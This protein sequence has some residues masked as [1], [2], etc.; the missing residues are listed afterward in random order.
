MARP[1]EKKTLVQR[2]LIGMQDYMLPHCKATDSATPTAA[3]KTHVERL[4]RV[5][6]KYC[7]KTKSTSTRALFSKEECLC[8]RDVLSPQKKVLKCE[9]VGMHSKKKPPKQNTMRND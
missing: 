8:E 1:E 3:I 7:A 9:L 6:T 5:I 2:D 4:Y